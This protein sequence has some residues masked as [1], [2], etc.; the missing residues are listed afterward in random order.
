I[1]RMGFD[2]GQTADNLKNYQ[3]SGMRQK[4]VEKD[5]ILYIED[6]YNASPDS[7]HAAVNV[8]SKVAKGRKIAVLGDM[9]ELG[10]QSE[11][12]HTE[13]GVYAKNMGVDLL[14]CTGEQAKF[15]CDG[16]GENA[17]FFNSKSQVAQ[18]IKDNAKK[19]DTIIFK[20]SNGMKF[21]EIIQQ[22]YEK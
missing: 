19:G 3:P 21:W 5:G 14:L 4:P 1:S 6:C 9:L 16:F 15:I 7:M 13:V 10:E 20:A 22:V 8:L 2:A 17:L 18:Y 12:M 11:K